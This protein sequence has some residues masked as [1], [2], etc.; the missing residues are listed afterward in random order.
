MSLFNLVIILIV[1]GVGLYLVNL[2]P[3]VDASMK[4]IINIVVL[5]AVVLWLLK[6][7][8]LFQHLGIV[9]VG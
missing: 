8:G 4:K 6:V 1:I 2:I 5:I 3:I 7:F 9:H